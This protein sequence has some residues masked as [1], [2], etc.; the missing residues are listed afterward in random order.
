M[1]KIL[2]I[3]IATAISAPAMADLTI[4]GNAEYNMLD[5]DGTLTTGL[6]TNLVVTGSSVADNGNF[7]TATTTFEAV[8]ASQ[9][10]EAD[11]N[12]DNMSLNF[13]TS[14]VNV[15]VGDFGTKSAYSHGSDMAAPA[16]SQNGTA[17]T[18]FDADSLDDPEDGV[19]IA[20]NVTA[21]EGVE[22][23]YAT[24]LDTADAT[25]ITRLYAS[26][27]VGGVTLKANLQDKEGDSAESGWAVSAA[28]TISDVAVAF[29]YAKADDDDTSTTV[30]AGY[31][32]LDLAVERSDDGAADAT[33]VYGSY[34][35]GDLGIPGAAFKV[36]AGGG[37]TTADEIGLRVNYTF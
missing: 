32:G 16:A 18:G 7:I 20:I 26:T 28:T 1:K 3:A 24:T 12:I 37:D 2:A 27:T 15:V 14:Q 13:G 31:M 22:L 9:T 4:G 21:I 30:T 8:G 25:A 17:V 10:T 36:G 34:S 29:S 33:I 6:E 5:T 19:D 35:L 23:Q 11:L